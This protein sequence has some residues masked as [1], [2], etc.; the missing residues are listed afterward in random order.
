MASVMSATAFM[1]SHYGKVFHIPFLAE[2][3]IIPMVVPRLSG[4][5][6][7]FQQCV[8]YG[9]EMRPAFAA[10]RDFGSVFSR[11]FALVFLYE[12]SSF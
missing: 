6:M 10:Q 12:T 3:A 7:Y 1:R 8:N 9:K 2:G 5:T 11:P 4:R